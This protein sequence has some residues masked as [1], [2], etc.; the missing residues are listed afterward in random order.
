MVA[1][2]GPVSERLIVAYSVPPEVGGECGGGVGVRPVE[3]HGVDGGRGGGADRGLVGPG[4]T[5]GERP[6]GHQQETGVVGGEE[7]VA[8][9]PGLAVHAVVVCALVVAAGD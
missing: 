1:R 6:E 9:P 8:G 4:V 7:A 3:R 5:A 2:C